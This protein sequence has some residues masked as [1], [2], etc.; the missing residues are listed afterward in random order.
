MAVLLDTDHLT[1]LLREGE[2]A[3]RL[4]G[5]L[6]AL[7]PDDV[8]TSIVTF[9]EQFVGWLGYL[10]RAKTEASLLRAYRELDALLR[11]F[12]RMN[13]LP[14][15]EAALDRFKS[16][17]KQCRRVGTLDLRIASIALAT[18]AMLLS[19]NLRDFRPVPGLR[20]EDWTL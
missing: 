7:P 1:I 4:L 19:G 10:N 11:W 5:R 2:P 18:D 8:A 16:I 17:R 15:D 3:A 20:V 13:V 9:Q 12:T 6:S 14:F